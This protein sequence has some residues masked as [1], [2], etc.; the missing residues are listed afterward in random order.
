MPA[1]HAGLGLA[2]QPE[3]LVWRDLAIDMLEVALPEWA[4]R[5]ISL[6]LVTPPSGIRPARVEV[7]MDFLT[8]RFAKAPWAWD[9]KTGSMGAPA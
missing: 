9:G 2:L 6:N 8:R 4:P 1:L 7:L 5:P 3:F